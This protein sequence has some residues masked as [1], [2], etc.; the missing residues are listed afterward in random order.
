[1][2]AAS[3]GDGTP[4]SQTSITKVEELLEK[5]HNLLSEIEQ[6]Q[7][8][9][10]E[11]KKESAVELRQ[12][13]NSVNSELKSLEKLSTADPSAERTIHALRS[14]NLPFYTAV[15]NTAKS[16]TGL[17]TFF[18]RFY[19]QGPPAEILDKAQKPEK[20]CALVD[21]VA[22][23]G[24][25]WIK[26]STVT[27]ARLLFEKAKAHWEDASSSP[28][29]SDEEEKEKE[30][31]NDEL[32]AAISPLNHNHNF[33]PTTALKESSKQN[34]NN[35]PNHK[36]ELLTVAHDLRLA[37][38]ATRIRYKHPTIRF[39]LPK[40]SSGTSPEIDSI[41]TSI[42]NTGVIVH[43][44]NNPPPHSSPLI[45]IPLPTLFPSLL[46][47]PF[48]P[49]TP[50]L[51][52]DCT[53]LLAL[54]SDL[55]HIPPTTILSSSSSSSQ[56][57]TTTTTPPTLHPSLLRQLTLETSSPLLPTTLYPAL[58][59]RHLVC[60]SPAATRMREITAQIGTPSEQAR[61]ELIFSSPSPLSS[62][63]STLTTH[64]RLPI[65]IV[66]ASDSATTPLLLSR[67][68]PV[69]KSVAAKLSPINQSVFLYGW[70]EGIATVS[71]NRGVVRVV[72]ECVG[73]EGGEEEE[74]EE[75]EEDQEGA[76]GKEESIKNRD[77]R[78]PIVEPGPAVW[79]VE[80]A[81][82]LVGREKG[83][84]V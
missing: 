13:R 9:L 30:E 65:R 68:P 29:E 12:L 26:V 27:E 73:R 63:A 39:V 3:T 69:A 2:Q 72:E 62:S 46:P 24:E 45:P 37:S 20:R 55:S 36:L 44:A 60:T 19:W 10:V 35:D 18:K 49:L 56:T 70:A 47:S 6:F 41:I 84:R 51:N 16:C 14:S 33:L 34:P 67:L 23:N 50:T 7:S 53:I 71:S 75:E 21:I 8:F 54:V 4:S 57:P 64:L 82:S 77:D 17:I 1:M 83:R 25:E 79:L 74:E 58:S 61:A 42:R 66:P 80:V 43:C 78:G 15:W 52:L 28:E 31:M 48:P 59:S 81:R 5:C 38:L 40:V 11:Q 22:Q 76:K 32:V